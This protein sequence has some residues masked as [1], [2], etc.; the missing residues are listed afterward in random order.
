[1]TRKDPDIETFRAWIASRPAVSSLAEQRARFEA[2]HAGTLLPEGCLTS[3]AL[4][5]SLVVEQ[6][7]PANANLHKALLYFHGGGHMFGSVLSHRHL[8]ARLAAAAGVTAFSVD[9][10]LAPEHPFPA[11]LD[12]AREAYDFLLGQ[13]FAPADLVVGGES[14]GANLA[15]ALLLRLGQGR[16]APPAGLYLLSPWLDMA[17]RGESMASRAATDPLISRAALLAC[18]D[19]YLAG[20][21]PD[22]P[23]ASPLLGDLASLP[24]ILV[25]ASADEV[26]LSDAL[27]FVAKAAQAGGRVD[28]QIRQEMVHAWPLFHT[29]I[30]AGLAAIQDAGRWI[31]ARLGETVP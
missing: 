7:I 10:R 9:Y 1:M 25:Q 5:G 23:Q 14:A 24:P 3:R 19:A 2:E 4:A 6:L 21:S 16:V 28:L 29:R 12:D 15:A 31:A 27:N 20:A 17:C 11:G 22:D 8:V 30:P 26:L 18:A 13:G